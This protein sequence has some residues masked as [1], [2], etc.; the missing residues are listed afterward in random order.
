MSVATPA[1]QGNPTFE[2]IREGFNVI[3]P[4]DQERFK[5]LNA[6]ITWT[7]G[8]TDKGKERF[9]DVLRQAK[10]DTLVIVHGHSSDLGGMSEQYPDEVK[11][12]SGNIIQ[13]KYNFVSIDEILDKY[14][15]PDKFAAVVLHGCNSEKGSVEAKKVPVFYPMSSV[16]GVSNPGFFWSPSGGVSLPK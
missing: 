2:K 12:K 5:S 15:D 10:G 3:R 16:K 1:K 13:R 6:M 4:E 9:N 14:N 8:P 11:D 7:F